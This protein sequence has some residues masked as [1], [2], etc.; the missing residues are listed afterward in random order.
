M[1]GKSVKWMVRNVVKTGS[2]YVPKC[3]F[4]VLGALNFRLEEG[5]PRT[6]FLT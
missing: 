6:H 4:T 1:A 3:E 5:G 2:A